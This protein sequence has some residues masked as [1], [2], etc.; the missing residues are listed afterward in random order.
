M[1][2]PPHI[3]NP[4]RLAP[5]MGRLWAPLAAVTTACNGKANAQI[6]VAIAAASIVPARPRI[7]VQIYKS[8]Y[9]HQ[10]IHA[11]GILAVNFLRQDQLALIKQFGFVSGRDAD[12]LAGVSYRQGATGSP[13]LT[14]C[15]GYLDCRVVNA[16]DGGDMT[17]FL[18]EVLE[19]DTLSD[20]EP[21]SW[22]HA[23]RLLPREWAEEWDRRIAAEIQVSLRRMDDVRHDPWQSPKRPVS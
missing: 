22:R 18:A 3:E 19:G 20:D 13:I 7:A 11:S 8:N 1:Q 10:L 12:K 2:L 15:W 9:T 16:M 21:L 14:Q 23:R 4:Q 17:C 6:A 5:L